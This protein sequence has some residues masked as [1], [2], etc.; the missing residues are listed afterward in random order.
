[1]SKAMRS[2]V[3]L[4]VIILVISLGFAGFLLVNKQTLEQQN[5]GL[6]TQITDEQNRANELQSK[7]KKL[8]KDQQ[9]LNDR[10]SQA[11]K[12]KD[13]T[14]QNLNDL[15]AKY[16]DLNA[17]LEQMS[18]ERDEW[19]AK[20]D[21]TRKERDSL[22][23]KLKERPK[24]IV[25]KIVYK[26]RD[27]FS[28][29]GTDPLM[30]GGADASAMPGAPADAN[31]VVAAPA[32]SASPAN[33]PYWADVLKQKTA[34]KLDL[35]K[36]K[37]DLDKSL[38]QV[39]ELKKI[40]AEMQMELKNLTDAKQDIERKMKDTQEEYAQKLKYSEEMANNL[41]ME[42]ARARTDQREALQRVEKIKQENQG[43]QNQLRDLNNTKLALE[44]T[45]AQINEDKLLTQKKLAETQG[46]IQGRI[47]EIWQIKQNL[48][49]K[50]SNMP[51]TSGGEVELP[52]IIV[53]ANGPDD[54]APSPS[55]AKSSGAVISINEPNN[56]VIV[57]LGEVDG[58]IVG[59]KMTVTR[60][61]STIADLQVIQ[62]RKDISAAD[63]KQ[64]SGK[65]KVGDVVR[66]Q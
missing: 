13:E 51:K 60:G 12:S 44:K 31:A 53:N 64:S 55:A 43:L 59:R 66:F 38:I 48:D 63:I 37:T 35:D 50:I 29:G 36:A 40:N 18:A 41:S 15:K 10:L 20:L 30:S 56:F 14:E 8:E 33:D 39:V 61:N 23:E 52:P 62:V 17:Q 2:A 57:D 11:I 3:I 19:K 54:D 7:A 26:D 21:T 25:E 27:G 65:I 9:D 46:V 16:E 22:M 4:L 58:S 42:T 34:L 5:Q 24:E 32:A 1:M 45:I 28:A 49:E 6:Q 47:D